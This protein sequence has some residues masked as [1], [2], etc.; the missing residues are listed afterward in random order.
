M[1]IL[2]NDDLSS[3]ISWLPSGRSFVIYNKEAFTK[4]VLPAFFHKNT[5][6]ASFTRRMR[7][8]KFSRVPRPTAS[9]TKRYP[10]AMPIYHHP[11]FSKDSISKCL[12]MRPKPQQSYKRVSQII[13]NEESSKVSS[14]KA[15]TIKTVPE[16]TDCYGTDSSLSASSFLQ[17]KEDVQYIPEGIYHIPCPKPRTVSMECLRAVQDDASDKEV[18]MP[19]EC[20][21]FFPNHN[22]WMERQPTLSAIASQGDSLAHSLTSGSLQSSLEQKYEA[23][24]YRLL[25]VCPTYF[26]EYQRYLVE[27][28]AE[29][30]AVLAEQM[31]MSQ[32]ACNHTISGLST[33]TLGFR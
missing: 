12:Q 17:I 7:R 20:D 25:A 30:Q 33:S 13:L 10:V 21:T 26:R 19:E 23:I 1:E 29:H 28:H 18:E 9:A 31:Y 16:S 2:G 11:L 4:E 32:V 22:G 6:Y 8:W 14:H 27:V 15:V 24:H 5:K 3:I